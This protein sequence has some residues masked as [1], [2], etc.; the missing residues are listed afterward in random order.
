MWERNGRV[1]KKTLNYKKCSWLKLSSFFNTSAFTSWFWWKITLNAHL[2]SIDK[3]QINLKSLVELVIKWFGVIKTFEE[4][5]STNASNGC[6]LKDIYHTKVEVYL[7]SFLLGVYLWYEHQS[8]IYRNCK[9]LCVTSVNFLPWKYKWSFANVT[10]I[11][12]PV[13]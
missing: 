4:S 13:L 9:N 7:K 5:I 12:R 6:N 2:Y 11:F 8:H 10:Q 1:L 3:Y